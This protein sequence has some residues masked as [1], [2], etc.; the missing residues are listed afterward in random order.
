MAEVRRLVEKTPN[1][2]LQSSLKALEAEIAYDQGR[3]E[4]A[5]RLAKQGL[6]AADPGDETEMNLSLRQA[7]VL[8]RTGRVAD[9]AERAA[10]VLARFEQGRLIGNAASARLETGEASLAAGD[11]QRALNFAMEALAFFEPRRI[12]ESV[13]RG[14]L[15]AAK[16]SAAGPEA[17]AHSTAA[18]EA[19]VQLKAVWPASSVEGYLERPDIK[20][21]SSG[22]NF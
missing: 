19:L 16:A 21:L 14:R 9:G 20:K 22:V 13:W 3:W 8:I 4:N 7:L 18:A 6:D 11:Q 12:W 5:A 1:P 2:Q 17:K 15:V 10:R